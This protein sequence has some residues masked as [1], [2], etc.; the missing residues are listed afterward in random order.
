MVAGDPRSRADHALRGKPSQAAGIAPGVARPVRGLHALATS[1]AV[2]KAARK[3]V[4][5][6]AQATGRPADA[7]A[8]P[9]GPSA[10][11]PDNDGRVITALYRHGAASAGEER[12]FHAVAIDARSPRFDGGIAT[13]LDSIP[14]GIVV[15]SGG[16]RFYDEGEELWP[17][18]YAI[19]G[20]LIAE[21]P[22]Q[23]AYAIFDAATA[24]RFIPSAFAPE[25]ADTVEALAVQLGLD[26]AA[27]ARTVAR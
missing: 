8:T 3:P 12:G 23:I 26:G 15:N 19:W 7:A 13:R 18:R 9:D 20:K 11:S 17:K 16:R 10:V 14:F 2:G 4:G 1:S 24:D 27:L 25:R 22:G 6:L 21:L 5:V